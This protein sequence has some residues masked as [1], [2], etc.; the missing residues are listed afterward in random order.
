MQKS[1]K[2]EHEMSEEKKEVPMQK[3]DGV[4]LWAPVDYWSLNKGE[5]EDI[6]NG[7]GPKG[8]GWAVPDTIW[9]LRITAAANIH[10]YMYS[11]RHTPHNEMERIRADT[12][13]L[14]NMV[15][16]IDAKTKWRWLKA[17]RGRRAKTY[18]NAV[19]L[20]G[21]PAYWSGKNLPVEIGAT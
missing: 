14:N 17:L 16:I 3:E 1:I 10:D 21:G 20:F 4:R 11:K 5:K 2:Q 8:L 13:F 7:A 12:S 19:R 18:Y 15:R 6:C 9:G